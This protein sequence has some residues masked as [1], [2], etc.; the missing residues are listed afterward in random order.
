MT[1]HHTLGNWI[2]ACLPAVIG[3]AIAQEAPP[4]RPNRFFI[5]LG[6]Y[7]QGDGSDETKAIQ[8][9]IDAIP[10]RYNWPESDPKQRGATVR[11]APP[12]V[13]WGI[14]DA[15]LLREVEHHGRVRVAG[16]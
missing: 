1:R 5:N 3:P 12:G 14:Q 11:P 4:E 2:I 6:D 8:R 9:A 10:S 15:G 7:A 16:L 13:L